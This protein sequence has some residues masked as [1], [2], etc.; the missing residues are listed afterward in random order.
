MKNTKMV[1]NST[2][3]P[4]DFLERQAF[5]KEL[6]Q[7]E[8]K[9][10][11]TV[12]ETVYEKIE[13]SQRLRLEVVVE[14]QKVR[15]LLESKGVWVRYL[16]TFAQHARSSYRWLA[17]AE[18]LKLPAPVIEGAIARGVDLIHK[19][20]A[21][22]L[23]AVPPPKQL[24]AKAVDSYLDEI[25]EFQ[26]PRRRKRA[27]DGEKAMV[28]AWRAVIKEWTALE[29]LGARQ[30][31]S[32]AVRLI[33]RLMG[34]MG[35]PAQKIEAEAVPEAFRPKPGYPKGRPRKRHSTC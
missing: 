16:Q 3:V 29:A 6:T 27:P 35:L 18:Q 11:K 5:W 8:Q 33:G 20:Y 30:R 28:V 23:E 15:P 25:I 7:S 19:S 12:T 9:T 14:L 32:W 21:P 10:V 26:A 31:A 1:I 13:M 22:A 24:G 17:R 34:E 2:V 4:Q